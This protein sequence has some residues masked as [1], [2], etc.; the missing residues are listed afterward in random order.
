[1]LLASKAFP[2]LQNKASEDLALSRF[3]DQLKD[4]Q[5]SFGVKQCHPRIIQE[6]VSNTI[7]MESYLVKSASSKVMQVTKKDPE[8]QAT[9]AV[10]QST[11]CESDAKAGGEVEQLELTSQKKPVPQVQPSNQPLK[12]NQA[13]QVDLVMCYFCGQPD[14]FARGCAQPRQTAPQQTPKNKSF[15]ELKAPSTY[16]INS[17]SSDLLSCSIYNSPVSFL[18]DTGTR[19]LLLSKAVW[20]NIKPAKERFNPMV[21]HRLVGVDGIP[22][23]VEGTVSTP[24][25]IG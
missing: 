25:K 13:K 11:Q 4:P 5:V 8:E 16:S 18:I 7:K 20:D 23:K 1:M 12:R 9:V 2:S 3:L 10:I 17:V 19:V 24:I 6:A 14:Y 22:I 15:I 21:T